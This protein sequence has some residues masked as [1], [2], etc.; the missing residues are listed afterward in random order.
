MTFTRRFG[1]FEPTMKQL[2]KKGFRRSGRAQMSHAEVI[3]QF[4]LTPERYNKRKVRQLSHEGWRASC[5][6]GYAQGKRVFCFPHIDYVR[7]KLIE[8]YKALWMKIIPFM[9]G[10]GCMVLIPVVV[11][12]DIENVCDEIVN[13]R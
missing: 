4:V 13:D 11:N 5:A 7:P 6:V 8:E 1:I 10:A 2:V 3:E 9:T 12:A